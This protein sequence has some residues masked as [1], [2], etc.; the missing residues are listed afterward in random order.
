MAYQKNKRTILK[1]S[2]LKIV[3]STTFEIIVSPVYIFCVSIVSLLTHLGMQHYPILRKI[4]LKL[5]VT[6]LKNDYYSPTFFEER[7]IYS[8]SQIPSRS[9][10]GIVEKLSSEQIL[11]EKLYLINQHIPYGIEKLSPNNTTFRV[12]DSGLLYEML[13]KHAPRSVVEIGS[14]NSTKVSLAYASSCKTSPDITCIEPY[15]CDWLEQTNLNIIRTEVQKVGLDI[16]EKCDFLIIDTSHVLRE[17]GDVH[18]IYSNIL[19]VIKSGTIIHVHDIFLPYSFDQTWTYEKHRFW[20]EQALV[21][22]LVKNG[23]LKFI[24]SA[25]QIEQNVTQL[26]EDELLNSSAYFVKI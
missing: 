18:H 9:H 26:K 12:I 13:I 19:P 22:C 20:N 11:Y 5:D 23:V 16:F 2:L 17:G 10:N 25:S 4:S 3:R 24:C 6:S 21:S 15:E 1:V 8:I 14:G 7:S